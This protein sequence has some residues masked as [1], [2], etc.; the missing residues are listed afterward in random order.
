MKAGETKGRSNILAVLKEVGSFP[1]D[2][3]NLL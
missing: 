2:K 1:A 3:L